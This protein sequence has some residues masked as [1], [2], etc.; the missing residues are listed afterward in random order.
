MKAVAFVVLATIAACTSTGDRVDDD[1]VTHQPLSGIRTPG[2]GIGPDDELLDV[3]VLPPLGSGGTVAIPRGGSPCDLTAPELQTW[4]DETLACS[5]CYAIACG[6]EV[7]AHV[8]TRQCSGDGAH[9]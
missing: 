7:A 3:D 4:A 2:R 8:C 5:T 1:V 9:D 6:G